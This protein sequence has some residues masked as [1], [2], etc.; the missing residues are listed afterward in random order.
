MTVAKKNLIT[1]GDVGGIG[2]EVVLKALV[3]FDIRDFAIVGNKDIF[4]K[5][6]MELNISLPPSIEIIDIPYDFSKYKTGEPTAEN[7]KHSM[8]S[9]LKCCELVKANKAKAI[10]TAPISKK[11]LNMAGFNY[12]GQ[13]EILKKYLKVP[14][15]KRVFTELNE[16]G[17]SF[18][19]EMLFVAGDLKVILMTRHI[20]LAEVAQNLK[21]KTILSSIINLNHSLKKDFNIINPKIAICALNPHAGED[22]VIGMEEEYFF[23]P[24]IQQLR[25]KYLI[26]VEGPF[27]SDTLWA[28]TAKAYM[29]GEKLPYD[30]YAACYHDQGLIPV[31]ML[32]MDSAVNVTINLPVIRTS[33]CHGTAYDIAGKGI[34]NH[35]SMAESIKLLQ[36]LNA[37]T[38]IER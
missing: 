5:T 9:L 7:G 16:G 6:A 33:P 1:L 21:T 26:D 31:K 14:K 3:G 4:Y 8:L 35:Q 11:A 29:N 19:P 22:G 24:A 13:T 2:P 32:A 36:N 25:E 17:A 30:A 38:L 10:V 18:K 15:I 23:A 34:A 28:K 27:P 12:S 37:D 20:K